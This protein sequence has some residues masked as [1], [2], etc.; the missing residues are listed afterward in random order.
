MFGIELLRLSGSGSERI[1]YPDIGLAA[2]CWGSDHSP[3]DTDGA[4]A[5]MRWRHLVQV[6]PFLRELSFG[7]ATA[8]RPVH[9]ARIPYRENNRESAN[10]QIPN[11]LTKPYYP[12]KLLA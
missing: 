4:T 7:L 9:D 6:D 8:R 1:G 2:G 11:D 12:A 3:S 5:S 10:R